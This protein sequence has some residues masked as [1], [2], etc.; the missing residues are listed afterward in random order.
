MYASKFFVAPN[1]VGV[2]IGCGMAAVPLED[3]YKDAFLK[4]GEPTER[5]RETQ[6]LIKLGVP[7]GFNMHKK[8]VPDALHSLQSIT[9]EHPPSQWLQNI[10][11]GSPKVALQLGSLGGGNH[12]LEV[13]HDETGQVWLMLHSGSRWVGNNTAD[14][15]N[16]VAMQQM[17]ADKRRVWGNDEITEQDLN[18]LRIDSPE[19]QNYLQD[20]LWC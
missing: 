6:K 5:A 1:G 9:R 4:D 10:I 3:L 19:G 15:Y 16:K 13:L 12:F 18:S 8:A 7:C 17:K 2:D 20:M 11:N 14:H